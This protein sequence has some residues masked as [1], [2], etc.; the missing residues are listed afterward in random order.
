MLKAL[1]F[2]V[3]FFMLAVFSVALSQTTSGSTE[4]IINF[5]NQGQ[6]IMGTLTL[7]A[8]GQATH[9]T[10][11][12]LHGFTG[13]RQELPVNNTK[14]TMFS[15]TARLLAENGYASL[16]IDFRGSGESEGQWADTTFSGQISDAR[17]ALN[18]LA[19]LPQVGHSGF[20][21]GW[22]GRLGHRC[23]RPTGENADAVVTRGEP[24]PDLQ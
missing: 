19:G 6:K 12:I 4:Q 20:K 21:S 2:I 7:P 16:R 17:A 23:Q 24:V 8:N 5:Q 9:P 3:S 10:V 15:R 1:R 13:Q 22:T 14:E 11:L 18:Y